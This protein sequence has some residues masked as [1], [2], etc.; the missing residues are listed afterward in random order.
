MYSEILYGRISDIAEESDMRNIRLKFGVDNDNLD[1]IIY[2]SNDDGEHN[3]PNDNKIIDTREE[4]TE[5]VSMKDK[6]IDGKCLIRT[7]LHYYLSFNISCLLY[8]LSLWN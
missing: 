1:F 3:T 2:A 5:E 4:L 6:K 8:H 7:Y